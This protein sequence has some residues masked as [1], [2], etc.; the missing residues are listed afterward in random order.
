MRILFIID[1]VYLHG[2]IERV[3]SIK[4]NYLSKD[5]SNDIYVLT[6][7]QREKKPCYKFEDKITFEDLKINYDRKK[8][9][10]HPVN[11]VKSIFHAFKLRKKIKTINPEVIV[12]CSHSSDTHFIPFINKKIP[13]IKEFHYSKFIEEK[14]RNKP[15][16]TPKK[17]YYKVA[18]YVE[19]KYDRIVILNKDE[20]K[21]YKSDNVTFIP[22]PITFFPTKVS[23]LT[24][25]IIVS[26]GR[27][28]PVKGFDVLVD[29]WEMVVKKQQDWELHI[30]GTGSPTYLKKIQDKITAKGLQKS[31]ILK[32]S[33]KD[34]EGVFLNSSIFAMTSHNEC[35]P[36]VLL[37]SQACGLPIV[38]FDCPTGPRNIIDKNNGVL[39]PNKDNE[40]FVNQ[41]LELMNNQEKLIQMGTNAREN[42]SDFSVEKIM[43]L[44]VKLFNELTTI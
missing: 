15:G 6:T 9:Y 40:L 38:S 24:N 33:T 22:N 19:S 34:I 2:G 8:S 11:I 37:E 26:A 42:A 39:I 4:A 10:F 43:P 14:K 25:K 31:L 23:N 17:I 36:L 20:L 28:A 35:F 44:W 12:V 18:D 21:Y 3:L 13:K 32:G 1:Q 27:I 7:E 41:L 16:V 30:Y 5:K 29:I